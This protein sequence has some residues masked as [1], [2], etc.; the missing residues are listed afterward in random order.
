MEPDISAFFNR[1]YCI[2]EYRGKYSGPLVPVFVD[3]QLTTPR[4]KR[5]KTYYHFVKSTVRAYNNIHN[6]GIKDIE[7]FTLK[8]MSADFTR[9]LFNKLAPSD[10]FFESIFEARTCEERSNRKSLKH[11]TEIA[12]RYSEEEILKHLIK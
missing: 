8:V 1:I 10:D 3:G 9:Y 2:T 6:A 12:K 4:S 5:K 7:E 11:L